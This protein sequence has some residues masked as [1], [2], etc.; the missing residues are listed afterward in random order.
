MLYSTGEVASLLGLSAGQVRAFAAAGFLEPG[1]GT[2]GELR[3]SFQDLVLLRTAKELSDANVPRRT[4]VRSLL[5]LR[6]QLPTDRSLTELRITSDGDAV[7]ASDGGAA[8]NPQ[9]GQLHID[10]SVAELAARV[11]PLAASAPMQPDET[12]YDAEDWYA[13]GVELEAVEPEEARRAYE[14]A[15][16]IDEAH[17]DAH[18]N[19]G[20][21][22]HEDG[23][24]AEAESHYRSALAHGPHATAAYNLGIALEDLRRPVEA[25]AAYERAVAA[26][27]DLADAHYNLA[28]LYEQR[29]E[30]RA[31]L[32]HLTAY[33]TLTRAAQ[34]RKR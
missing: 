6:Q 31:A 14:R 33:R 34:G 27:R 26:D 25:I 11:Q 9:S 29:G 2:R 1:R 8:W 32:R 17:A 12:D 23:A 19:L 10:F 21:L 5:A 7:V 20:R 22:L 3:F 18:V 13:I 28:R 4:L 15:I 30:A 16:A 24:V